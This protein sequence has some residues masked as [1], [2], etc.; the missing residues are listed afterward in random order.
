MV[1]VEE[2]ALHKQDDRGDLQ[3]EWAEVLR[4]REVGRVA[5]AEALEDAGVGLEAAVAKL[6]QVVKQV[7]VAAIDLR[8]RRLN[9]RVEHRLQVFFEITPNRQRHVTESREDNRLDIAVNLCVLSIECRRETKKFAVWKT[10]RIFV[11]YSQMLQENK[12]DFVKLLGEGKRYCARQVADHSDRCGARLVV[13][14]VAQ[15]GGEEWLESLQ[16]LAEVRAQHCN[17][18]STINKRRRKI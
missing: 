12:H 1:R 18:E 6:R 2:H 10:R 8:R 15:S 13:L 17:K 11:A 9:Q 5:R 14:R 7:R 3:V 16:V 4:G